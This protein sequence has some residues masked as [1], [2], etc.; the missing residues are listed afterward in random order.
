MTTVAQPIIKRARPRARRWTLKEY[1]RLNDMGFFQGDRVELLD[2]KICAMPAL[3]PPHVAAV[4]LSRIALERVFGPAYWV[5]TQA[6]LHIGD[7]A[8]EP[9]LSVVAGGPRDY[10]RHPTSALLVMEVSDTTLLSDR[11]KGNL[12]ASGGI[13]DYWLLDIVHRRLEVRRSPVADASVK[14]FG[15]RYSA[16][17]M[18]APDQS[19]SP[20]A[21]PQA[22]V[23]I[24]DLLP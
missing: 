18:Y 7:S 11:W 8:P 16:I 3:N 13:Q 22:S 2:G 23:R 1:Y 21:M 5:R 9:D 15:H 4:D 19:V 17:F 12:S 6:P 14:R 10:T 20:L 24:A